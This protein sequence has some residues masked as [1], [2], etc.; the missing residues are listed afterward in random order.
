MGSQLSK[1]LLE[2]L[3]GI[4]RLSKYWRNRWNISTDHDQVSFVVSYPE[5]A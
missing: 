2:E 5:E 1:Y 3:L 4:D